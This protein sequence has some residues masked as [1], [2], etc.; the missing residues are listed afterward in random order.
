MTQYE[1]LD[2]IIGRV[3]HIL[4]QQQRNNL[5]FKEVRFEG[6]GGKERRLNLAL[7]DQFKKPLRNYRTVHQTIPIC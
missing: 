5:Q 3:S 6:I 1:T 7:S 2:P 4:T